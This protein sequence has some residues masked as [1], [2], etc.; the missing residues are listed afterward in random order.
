MAGS[1]DAGLGTDRYTDQLTSDD[2]VFPC[3]R[4]EAVETIECLNRADSKFTL[5]DSFL[6]ILYDNCYISLKTRCKQH[7]DSGYALSMSVR[8]N[9]G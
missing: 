9:V 1:S 7:V 5:I 4:A 6:S 3:T 8:A 2:S